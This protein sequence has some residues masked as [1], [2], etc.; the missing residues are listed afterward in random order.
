MSDY[1]KGYFTEGGEYMILERKRLQLESLKDIGGKAP[2]TQPTPR[3]LQREAV[4]RE[5]G[6]EGLRKLEESYEQMDALLESQR[7]QSGKVQR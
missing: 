3:D 4:L 7:Q 1:N 6:E 5:H 2:E